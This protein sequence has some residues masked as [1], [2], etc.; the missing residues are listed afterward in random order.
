[1]RTNLTAVLLNKQ[2][3]DPADAWGFVIERSLRG[4]DAELVSETYVAYRDVLFDTVVVNGSV[5]PK[6]AKDFKALGYPLSILRDSTD[7]VLRVTT[8]LVGY[9]VVLYQNEALMKELFWNYT[10]LRLRHV[11]RR[12]ASFWKQAI[13]RFLN[14]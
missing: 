2:V 9:D 13:K 6:V 5:V 11:H 10:L 3:T 1:M 12:M 7:G 14:R 8:T 4:V